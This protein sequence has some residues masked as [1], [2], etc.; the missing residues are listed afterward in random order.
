MEEKYLYEFDESILN[1]MYEYALDRKD[2]YLTNTF[3]PDESY[4]YMIG[5]H[6]LTSYQEYDPNDM[7]EY[8][9]EWFTKKQFLIKDFFLKEKE[10]IFIKDIL[11]YIKKFVTEVSDNII[12]SY[13]LNA[14]L[15]RKIF[16]SFD[17]RESL[18]TFV[19][20]IENL[21]I[22]YDDII[23]D[24]ESFN[25]K[26]LIITIWPYIMPYLFSKKI[27]ETDTRYIWECKCHYQASI[28]LVRKYKKQY[29]AW[30]VFY[31]RSPIEYTEKCDFLTIRH[32]KDMKY[33]FV[34]NCFELY[35]SFIENMPEVFLSFHESLG[36]DKFGRYLCTAI[37]DNLYT[38]PFFIGYLKYCKNSNIEPNCKSDLIQILQE[39]SFE[40]QA[41]INAVDYYLTYNEVVESDDLN[42][43]YVE[44]TKQYH[45][46]R[47]PHFTEDKFR[48]LLKRFRKNDLN[49]IHKFTR[50]EDW[51]FV[52]GLNGNTP[53]EG[54]KKVQWRGKNKKKQSQ[55]SPLKF[56]NFLEILGYKLNELYEDVDLL[57]R[58][59]FIA[60][61]DKDENIIK[62]DFNYKNGQFLH[63]ADYQ[64]LKKIVSEIGRCP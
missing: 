33:K 18:E 16:D 3:T 39:L 56:V 58:F 2:Y 17:D 24:K 11:P 9:A 20:K 57:N 37:I 62:K 36:D 43:N 50:E 22:G 21:N 27:K 7:L 63:V 53:P 55:V 6:I 47:L 49:Y 38:R 35:L 60:K 26:D 34:N 46:N 64:E 13:G 59:F 28:D 44:E 1:E 23:I 40:N 5:S 19:E 42:G 4:V 31:N 52:F 45:L 14:I 51:L 30:S 25:A 29:Y 10:P 48:E 32:L 54:F 41:S 15:I 8:V 61:D 12:S